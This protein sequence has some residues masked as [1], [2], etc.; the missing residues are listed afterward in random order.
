MMMMMMYIDDHRRPTERLTFYREKIRMIISLQRNHPIHSVFASMVGF[1]WSADRMALF[2]LG[3]N[4]IEDNAR[5]NQIGH[6]L[7]YFLLTFSLAH[8][9][10]R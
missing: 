9:A 3:P 4:A 10:C 7:Q 1:S 5:S 6:N 2:P 8:V